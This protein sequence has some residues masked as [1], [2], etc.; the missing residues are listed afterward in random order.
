MLSGRLLPAHLHPLPD[1]LFTSWLARLARAHELKLQSFSQLVFGRAYQLWNRDLD[2]LAPIW[3]VERLA[4]ITATPLE[5][6]WHTTLASYEGTVYPRH[7]ETGILRWV[8]N[9]GVYHRTRLKFGLQVCPHCLA[10][11]VD[12]YFRRSWRLAFVVCCPRHRVKLIDACP[13]CNRPFAFHRSEL[14]HPDRLLPDSVTQCGS[15]GTDVRAAAVSIEEESSLIDLATWHEAKSESPIA[16]LAV[17]HQFA[18]TLLS[19]RR[20]R[21]LYRV[22]AADPHAVDRLPQTGRCHIELLRRDERA[23]V[24]QCAA[25]LMRHP[26]EVSD[27]MSQRLLR[28]SELL[29]DFDDA[30]PA[31]SRWVR[32]LPHRTWSSRRRPTS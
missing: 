14:G 25:H 8:L 10:G 6:A 13:S 12:P 28:Y 15:C 20:E 32:S 16:R 24:L 22:L 11:D 9:V 17:L 2:R 29:R 23:R 26:E 5:R 3:V 30:P 1:E 19:T 4:E 27:L 21:R 31:Y 7:A 18:R